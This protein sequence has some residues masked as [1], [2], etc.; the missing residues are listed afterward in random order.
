MT[1]STADIH[2]ANPGL[3]S[4]CETQFR[5]FGKRLTFAGPCYTVKVY[6]D[7]RRVKA[8]AETPGED[9]VLVVDGGGSLR[10]GLM[11][12]MMAEIAMRSGWAGAVIH[13]VV[14]D[15]LAIDA[16]EFGVKAIGT[17]ARRGEIETGGATGVPVAF[18]GITFQPGWW[19]YADCDAVIVSER[20]LTAG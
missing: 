4:V 1:L 8:V 17:T 15:S 18:G 10:V 20:A 9:R 13:G 7:H 3:V 5:S 6:E 14:R 2:D 19:V 11:G 16:L 12:D